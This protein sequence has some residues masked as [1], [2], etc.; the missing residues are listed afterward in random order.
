MRIVYIFNMSHI[1]SEKIGE[2]N[3]HTVLQKLHNLNMDYIFKCAF[4]CLNSLRLLI[5]II[6]AFQL[7]FLK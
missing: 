7:G 6:V 4:L 3:V 1:L 2:K 5:I